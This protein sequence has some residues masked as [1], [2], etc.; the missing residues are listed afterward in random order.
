MDHLLSEV[1]KLFG[2]GSVPSA[3]CLVKW[4]GFDPLEKESAVR[5]YSGKTWSDVLRHYQRGGTHELEAWA[6][7]SEPS[8]SYYGRAQLEYLFET[9]DSACPDADFISQFFHQLYQLAYMHQG[10][11]FTLMQTDLLARIAKALPIVAADRDLDCLIDDYVVHNID[12]YLQELSR[13]R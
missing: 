13:S 8:L 10:S 3:N 2:L 4:D 1:Q 5:F 12:L 11:P 9:V 7:L 6:V